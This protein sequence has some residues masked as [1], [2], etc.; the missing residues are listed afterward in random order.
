MVN[1]GAVGICLNSMRW[2]NTFSH[3]ESIGSLIG[4]WMGHRWQ[5][6]STICRCHQYACQVD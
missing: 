4:G 6:M 1:R 2:H 5:Q 3:I